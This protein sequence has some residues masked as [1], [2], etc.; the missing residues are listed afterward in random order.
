M[1]VGGN[2]KPRN[3]T[4]TIKAPFDKGTEIRNALTPCPVDRYK[5]RAPLRIATETD[6]AE[7]PHVNAVRVSVDPSVPICAPW[8]TDK[9]P[10]H[11]DEFLWLALREGDIQVIHGNKKLRSEFPPYYRTGETPPWLSQGGV[12]QAGGA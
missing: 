5:N 3:A 10:K 7:A 12:I 1:I 11:A 9:R 4:S 8:H 2:I 6:K